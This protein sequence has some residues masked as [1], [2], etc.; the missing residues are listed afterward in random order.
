M[1]SQPIYLEN[2]E[3]L[4][5]DLLNLPKSDFELVPRTE[6]IRDM[7]FKTE[8]ISY[9]KDVFKRFVHKKVSLVAACIILFVVLMAIIGP[10]LTGYNYLKQDNQMQRMPPKMQG[11]EKLGIFDGSRTLR[12]QAGNLDNYKDNLIKIVNE[13][14]VPGRGRPVQMLTIKVDAYK[15]AGRPDEY[16][17]FGTD[18]LG[19]DLFTRLWMGAR[20]SLIMAVAVVFVNM[21][22]GLFIG[23]NAGY[24]GG[25]IDMLICRW[26][27]IMN[28]IPSLPLTVLLIMYFGSGLVPLIIVFVLT[29][30]IGMTYSTR[31]QYYRYKTK[32]Y[33]LA[34]RT[35][36][37]SDNRIK[38]IY[39]L[40]NAVGTII[41]SFA[42]SIPAVIFQE[43][44]LSYIGLGIQAPEPSIGTMLYDGQQNLLEYPY[45]IVFPGLIIVLL[46][47]SFNLFSNGL[48][49]AFN[50]A[51]RQ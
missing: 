25:I 10:S 4:S 49:D 45:M 7:E 29:G 22:I 47:L 38:Y 31:I 17:W 40:P 19:R 21:T 3:R 32:E 23:S 33:V 9:A 34:S 48:R 12:I 1:I 20:I 15:M 6:E 51:L 13:Y 37:A 5:E 26:M 46:M 18:Y 35:M 8:A 43:A 11:I 16:H 44:G 30:W 28:A 42:L 41:T 27:E 14:E 39:I 2:D 50:P 36:G 24:Y